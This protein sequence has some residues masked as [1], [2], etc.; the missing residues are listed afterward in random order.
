ML[1]S[2]EL[3]YSQP[4]FQA[5]LH[6]HTQPNSSPGSVHAQQH[7]QAS[8]SP[9]ACQAKMGRIPSLYHHLATKP[10]G[11]S[12]LKISQKEITKGTLVCQ[13]GDTTREIQH[14]LIP[15]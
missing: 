4:K 15:N 5:R 2:A 10:F 6:T 12:K 11:G 9:H 3:I 8:E 7:T 13:Y 14:G 1:S